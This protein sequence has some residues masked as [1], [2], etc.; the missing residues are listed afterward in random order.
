MT[1]DLDMNLTA[2]NVTR[3][4]VDCLFDENEI[5]E[6]KEIPDDAIVVDAVVHKYGF[7]PGRLES[8]RQEIALMLNDLPEDFRTEG[9]MSFLRSHLDKEGRQWGEH[10]EM[11]ILFA[12]ALALKL[13]EFPITREMWFILPGGVPFIQVDQSALNEI[14][15]EP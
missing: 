4:G 14:I 10:K 11:E 8:H 12:L 1:K 6:G 7:H 15:G 5:E 9:G 2:E 3:V 13:A